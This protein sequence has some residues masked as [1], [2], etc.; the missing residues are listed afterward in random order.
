MERRAKRP[1][2][3]PLPVNRDWTHWLQKNSDRYFI[4]WITNLCLASIW[5][6]KFFLKAIRIM[7][8]RRKVLLGFITVCLISLT[9]IVV[10]FRHKSS[11]KWTKSKDEIQPCSE[12]QTVYING[13]LV[14]QNDHSFK[15]NSQNEQNWNITNLKFRLHHKKWQI[16]TVHKQSLSLSMLT[17][18]CTATVK[19]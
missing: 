5:K 16:R 13:R 7:M 15:E 11:L 19:N 2:Y 4:A 14:C 12:E 17:Q 6:L 10:K 3:L 8:L 9:M 1:Q 18:Y